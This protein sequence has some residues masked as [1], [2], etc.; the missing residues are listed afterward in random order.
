[1]LTSAGLKY[2]LAFMLA[3]LGPW[4]LTRAAGP[5]QQTGLIPDV[6]RLLKIGIPTGLALAGEDSVQSGLATGRSAFGRDI[7]GADIGAATELF[8]K[9]WG[10]AFTVRDSGGLVEILSPRAYLCLAGLERP[11]A[12]LTL[13]GTPLEVLFA[14]VVT[15]D[16]SLKHLPPPAMVGAGP[17]GESQAQDQVLFQQV[18]VTTEDGDLRTA[19]SQ[20]AK[21]SPGLGWLA[22][23]QCGASGEC[24]CQLGLVTATALLHTGYDASVGIRPERTPVT[25]RPQ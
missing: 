17:L 14:I 25:Q 16:S 13:V 10:T 2:S 5:Q 11:V 3:I 18:S 15:F 24:R 23:E 8:T 21:S 19:L 4:G 12:G 1:M 7:G 22:Q 6:Q 9:K 20:L